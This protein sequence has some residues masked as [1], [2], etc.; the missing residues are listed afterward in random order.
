NDP[1]ILRLSIVAGVCLVTMVWWEL[2]PRNPHP[3]VNFR[4]L[5][6]REL[7][8]SIFLF[9]AL[10]FGLYGGVF[11]FPLFTQSLL[12]FTPTE[13]GLALL[14]GGLA[15]AVTA[16]ICGRLLNGPRPM[17]DS[18]ALIALRVAICVV[19]VW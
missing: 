6:N 17:V 19:A 10:G 9:V 2:S 7:A 11:I 3:V 8:A 16:L 12:H 1:W 4:V 14:P 5:K 18:G 13:T 15:T